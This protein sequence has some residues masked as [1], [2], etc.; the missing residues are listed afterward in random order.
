VDRRLHGHQEREVAAAMR[1]ASDFA[2]R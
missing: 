2:E 1:D